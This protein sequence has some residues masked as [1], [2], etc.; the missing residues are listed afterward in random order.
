MKKENFF[1]DE[2]SCLNSSDNRY[3]SII[4]TSGLPEKLEKHLSSEKDR[5]L[6]YLY[7]ENRH[8][9]LEVAK[10]R[11]INQ[12]LNKD[13]VKKNEIIDNLDSNLAEVEEQ[14]KIVKKS[15]RN[16]ELL[17]EASLL[18]PNV[19]KSKDKLESCNGTNTTKYGNF[20][21]VD[22]KPKLTTTNTPRPKSSTTSVETRLLQ[23]V[24]IESL[25]EQQCE[26]KAYQ[27]LKHEI[28]KL[29]KE[30][31]MMQNDINNTNNS[32]LE[33]SN[34]FASKVNDEIENQKTRSSLTS[35]TTSQSLA[36]EL[37][38]PISSESLNNKIMPPRS[39]H[40]LMGE[41]ITNH[42]LKPDVNTSDSQ[43]KSETSN[44]LKNGVPIL[45]DSYYSSHPPTTYNSSAPYS[46]VT[47]NSSGSPNYVPPSMN[48][49]PYFTTSIPNRFPNAGYSFV[50]TLNYS[51]PINRNFNQLKYPVQSSI[52]QT[53]IQSNNCQYTAK[54][55]LIRRSITPFQTRYG[56]HSNS[57]IH[58]NLQ[59]FSSV[60]NIP[61]SSL[62]FLFAVNQS[63]NMNNYTVPHNIPSSYKLTFTPRFR[64]RSYKS[65]IPP[66]NRYHSFDPIRRCGTGNLRN[67]NIHNANFGSED[68]VNSGYIKFK[69]SIVPSTGSV[70]SIESKYSPSTVDSSS[71][72]RV[73]SGISSGYCPCNEAK[74][75]YEHFH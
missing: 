39:V 54:A 59:V 61:S 32:V 21:T 45:P 57:Q 49:L 63:N 6:E 66:N 70:T 15:Q 17:K 50:P 65:P 23:N 2:N 31:Y 48:I 10:L 75:C 22:I 30:V 18:Q 4:K 19:G 74:S 71:R 14:L 35:S 36:Q 8:L 16:R 68:S 43:R 73:P 1:N 3:K 7:E 28:E 20:N 72:V 51:Q 53:T 67:E 9:L 42:N 69:A 55:P 34:V 64:R 12:V 13:V 25:H 11:R 24:L 27:E 37:L 58:D 56:T 47:M 29:Q 5:E 26:R 62:P 41:T 52:Y 46:F 33:Q 38:E 60:N 44:L 40:L